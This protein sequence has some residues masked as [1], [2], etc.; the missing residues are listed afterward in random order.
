MKKVKN[1]MV[2]H[3]G[4]IRP[5]HLLSI[6]AFFKTTIKGLSLHFL[7]STIHP[8]RGPLIAALVSDRVSG[9]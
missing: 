2:M 6:N 7:C 4:F 1:T 3:D 5:N 8:G 9:L